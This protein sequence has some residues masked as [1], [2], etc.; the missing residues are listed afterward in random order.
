MTVLLLVETFGN[1]FVK[2]FEQ[3]RVLTWVVK[4]IV[5]ML[6]FLVLEL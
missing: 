5:V 6:G 1:P 4:L 2:V 3:Q